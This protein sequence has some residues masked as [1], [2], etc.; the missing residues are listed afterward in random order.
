MLDK[1]RKILTFDRIKNRFIG[2]ST[3]CFNSQIE[4]NSNLANFLTGSI[5]SCAFTVKSSMFLATKFRFKFSS[6][7][8]ECDCFVSSAWLSVFMRYKLNF[9]LLLIMCRTINKNLGKNKTT[10]VNVAAN[11]TLEILR[12]IDVTKF[13]TGIK[14][15]GEATQ[16]AKPALLNKAL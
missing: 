4:K 9:L 6:K 13:S 3:I 12:K 14:K 8:P 7:D 1:I 15:L 16:A 5:P 2:T 10:N 11:K